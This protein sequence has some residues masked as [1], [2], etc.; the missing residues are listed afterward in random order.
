MLP[1]IPW[2]GCRPF[3]SLGLVGPLSCVSDRTQLIASA[4]VVNFAAFLAST[5]LLY[6]LGRRV[7]RDDIAARV[8]A[9]FFAITPA[10][11]FVSAV[12]TER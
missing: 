6:A 7:L 12:Y 3:L 2:C 10:G 11:V 1:C 4:V 9:Y 8:A 5:A